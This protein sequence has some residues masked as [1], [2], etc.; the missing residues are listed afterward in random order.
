MLGQYGTTLT[1]P[2]TPLYDAQPGGFSIF[3][4]YFRYMDDKEIEI[5]VDQWIREVDA[6]NLEPEEIAVSF[7]AFC[8]EFN[9]PEDLGKKFVASALED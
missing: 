4:C 5:A 6:A 3:P 8:K 2:P 9:I 1:I 7:Q